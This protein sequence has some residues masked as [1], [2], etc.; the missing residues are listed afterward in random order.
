MRWRAFLGRGKCNARLGLPPLAVTSTDLYDLIKLTLL[1]VQSVQSGEQPCPF[2]LH[3]GLK[4][5][6]YIAVNMMLGR[7]LAGS[8]SHNSL[9]ISPPARR[10]ARSTSFKTHAQNLSWKEV[11][12][13]TAELPLGDYHKL[14]AGSRPSTSPSRS[15]M[16]NIPLYVNLVSGPYS[17]QANKRMTK[18]AH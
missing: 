18:A 14:P 11:T 12:E 15:P 4:T 2:A 1:H 6:P 9:R 16:A 10:G 13:R 17:S 5:F 7:S 8:S 3:R